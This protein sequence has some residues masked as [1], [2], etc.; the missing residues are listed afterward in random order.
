MASSSGARKLDFGAPHLR[1]PLS[2]E[3]EERIQLEREEA[4]LEV[5]KVFTTVTEYS[6]HMLAV[7]NETNDRLEKEN[8]KLR[9]QNQLLLEPFQW[10]EQRSR[11]QER[12]RSQFTGPTVPCPTRSHAGSPSPPRKKQHREAAARPN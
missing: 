4:D 9:L 3:D 12:L 1:P 5:L 6:M 11:D 10:M 8:C 7:A 2:K